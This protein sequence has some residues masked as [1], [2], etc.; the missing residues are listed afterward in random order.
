[1]NTSTSNLTPNRECQPQCK[2][3][4]ASSSF[5]I[6][7]SPI[8]R[9]YCHCTI[10][11]EFNNAAYGDVTI[12]LSKNIQLHNRDTVE[13]KQYKSPPAVQRG[14]CTSC[15]SPFIEFFELPLFPSLTIIPSNH[16]PQGEFLP[17]PAFHA[18]YHRRVADINDSLPKHSGYI[19]SQMALGAK[20]VPH[21]LGRDG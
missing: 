1:M 11:Q 3:Q 5:S 2:C 15:G 19:K 16:I 8:T 20:L 18:F 13:F 4:C 14:K 6:L 7:G 21:V 12:F 9:M 10:C 17:A